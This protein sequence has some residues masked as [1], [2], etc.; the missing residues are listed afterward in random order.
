[1]YSGF[2]DNIEVNK[3]E[4]PNMIFRNEINRIPFKISKS[5]F[6]DFIVNTFSRFLVIEKHSKIVSS[7]LYD[8][9]ELLSDYF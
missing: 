5:S 8:F 6:C 7:L 2:Y 4:C 1:M 3:N 9:N